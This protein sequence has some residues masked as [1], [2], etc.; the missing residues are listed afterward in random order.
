MSPKCEITHDCRRARRKWLLCHVAYLLTLDLA[1][2]TDFQYRKNVQDVLSHKF[3][4]YQHI[5]PSDC[6][7]NSS[8]EQVMWC[9]RTHQT[10][11]HFRYTRDRHWCNSLRFWF[12]LFTDNS[13]FVYVP[14]I[15]GYHRDK[16]VAVTGGNK[17]VS[18][19]VQFELVR[20]KIQNCH[21]YLVHSCLVEI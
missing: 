9:D 10:L 21:E 6:G 11:S 19:P 5:E 12:V 20:V 7:W 17:L 15:V 3:Q 16:L 2:T 18:V 14:E 1:K 13:V 8:F 4:A